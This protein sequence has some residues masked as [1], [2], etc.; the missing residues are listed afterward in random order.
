MEWLNDNIAWWH[1]IVFGLLLAATEIFVPSFFLLWLGVSAI[2]VGI[3]FNIISIS[4]SVQI[5]LWTLLSVICLVGWF[6]FIAP[7]MKD[8]TR[9]GMA[10]ESLIGQ[11]GLVVEHNPSTYRGRIKFPVPLLGEDEWAIICE[12][13]L[14]QG[15]RAQVVDVSG[16]SLVVKKI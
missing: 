14:R 7:R 6:R 3:V 4:F 8:K 1:W 13:E 5:F 2:V 15:D 16:N 9:S 11:S 12:A 10:M